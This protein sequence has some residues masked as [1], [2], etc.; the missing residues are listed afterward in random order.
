[1]NKKKCQLCFSTNWVPL[2]DPSEINCVTT[3]SRI[4]PQ[5]LGKSQC[6]K[7]GFTQRVRA[8]FLGFTDY[9]KNDYANY[10]ERPFTTK[11]HKARYKE[12]VNFMMENVNSKAKFKNVLDIGCGQGWAM[13]EFKLRFPNCNIEG[14]EPSDYNVKVAQEKGYKIYHGKLE[15]IK[16]KIKYDLIFSNNVVQHVTDARKFVSE[17]KNL[18]SK[19]GIILITCPDG[20]RPNIELLWGDQ[21]YSFLPQHLLQLGNNQG[22]EKCIHLLSRDFPELP[23]AQSITLTNNSSLLKDNIT[24]S[25]NY[26]DKSF[27][28]R[29]RTNYLA[30][31]KKIDDYLIEQIGSSK[32]VYNLGAS[33]WTS[34]LAAYCPKYWSKVN[35]CVIDELGEQKDFLGKKLVSSSSINKNL[36]VLGTSPAGHSSLIKKLDDWE[37]VVSWDQFLKY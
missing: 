1:M 37:K 23:P 24:V 32:E 35:A 19:N 12:I 10:Y 4:I 31:F 7:C 21:N 36:I 30:S 5:P 20:S 2:P 34:V 16:F 18:L 17:F 25:E 27:V 26:I 29:A 28:L 13:D 8:N 15:E 9:Y 14:V 6:K 22:F 3:A 11:F 33:Y